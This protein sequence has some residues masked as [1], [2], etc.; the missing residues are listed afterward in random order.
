MKVRTVFFCWGCE[1]QTDLI[2]LKLF[3]VYP[4]PNTKILYIIRIT[5]KVIKHTGM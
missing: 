2:A 5:Y 4:V 1:L 3:L